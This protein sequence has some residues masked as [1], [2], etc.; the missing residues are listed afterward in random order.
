MT[1]DF[2][3][4]SWVKTTEKHAP[5]NDG[6]KNDIVYS[7]NYYLSQGFP[8]SKINL[9]IPTYGRSWTLSSSNAGY[10]APASGLGAAGSIQQATGQLMYTEIC[11][12]IKNNGW[13]KVAGTA[14]NGPYAYSAAAAGATW[15]GFDDPASALTIVNYIKSKALGGAMVWD[16]TMD[17]STN[18]CG[19]GAN[20]ILTTISHA[21]GIS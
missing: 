14:N 4:W 3:G 7:V 11:L 1:Y 20:P 2:N 13:K 16:V 9:G 17:D 21:L 15:T 10:N 8:A 12:Y 5:L 6:S 19:G 18:A